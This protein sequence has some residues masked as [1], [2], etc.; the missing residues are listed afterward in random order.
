MKMEGNRSDIYA[1]VINKGG[2]IINRYKSWS[3][4][5]KQGWLT[6]S[7]LKNLVDGGEFMETGWLRG[8]WNWKYV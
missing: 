3:K 2:V 1:E 7:G 8:G 4:G 5:K 6:P